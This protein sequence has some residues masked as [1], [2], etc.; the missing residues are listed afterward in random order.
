MK[1][2]KADQSGLRW[3]GCGS[4]FGRPL[5]RWPARAQHAEPA[6]ETLGTSPVL[7]IFLVKGWG[8]GDGDDW[9]WGWGG[10]G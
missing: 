9:G 8:W 3:P 1:K 7:A 10:C 4:G 2:H 6:A 5:L